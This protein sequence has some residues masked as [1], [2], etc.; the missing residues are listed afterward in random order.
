MV[1]GDGVAGDLAGP[2]RGMP[3]ADQDAA[4]LKG[5]EELL[6][7]PGGRRGGPDVPVQDDPVRLAAGMGGPF[8]L[9]AG[10][11][12][13]GGAVRPFQH[14][15]PVLALDVAQRLAE[16]VKVVLRPHGAPVLAGEGGHDMDVVLTVVDR[17]PAH[18]LVL[19]AAL[20]Q[21]GAVHD[22]GGDRVPC[23][24]AEVGVFRRAPEHQVVDELVGDL[25][26]GEL[27]RQLE[28]PGQ[29]VEVAA[30]VGPAGRLQVGRGAATRRPG[31]G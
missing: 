6:L 1:Q 19:A 5:G 25:A 3:Q 30:A 4:G 21:P 14:A 8:H 7:G 28:L 20:G 29:P 23:A 15:Q 18:A 13:R 16:P 9:G 11:R 26:P 12:L 2:D 10:Q 31:A 17:Y 22:L 24:V 27:H